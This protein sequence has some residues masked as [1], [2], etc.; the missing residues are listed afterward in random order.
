MG[1]DN[2]YQHLGGDKRNKGKKVQVLSRKINLALSLTREKFLNKSNH[3][4]GQPWKI[5]RRPNKLRGFM[6]R[7]PWCTNNVAQQLE[8]GTMIPY[9]ERSERTHHSILGWNQEIL[10]HIKGRTNIDGKELF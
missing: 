4:W 3:R 8:W 6:G 10:G 5:Q 1:C 7:H 9:G 2:E